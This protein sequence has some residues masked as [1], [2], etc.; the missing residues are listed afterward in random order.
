M[1][2]CRKSK[3]QL[4]FSCWFVMD[5]EVKKM[6]AKKRPKGN[7]SWDIIGIQSWRKI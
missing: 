3:V 1:C 7:F 6:P 5:Q 4:S 2:I